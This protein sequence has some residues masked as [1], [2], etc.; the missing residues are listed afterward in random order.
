MFGIW[1][2]VILLVD[3]YIVNGVVYLV[4]DFYFVINVRLVSQIRFLNYDIKFGIIIIYNYKNLIIIF[5]NY[6]MVNII[7]YNYKNG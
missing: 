4:F 7:F 1:F 5:Y 6:K 3:Y 2:I